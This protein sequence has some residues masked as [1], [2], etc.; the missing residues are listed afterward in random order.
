MSGR[1]SGLPCSAQQCLQQAV[2]HRE[3]FRSLAIAAAGLKARL[4]RPRASTP[5]C[6]LGR[7][8][9]A[10][11][12]IARPG[13]VYGKSRQTWPDTPRPRAGTAESTEDLGDSLRS[14]GSLRPVRPSPPGTM[15]T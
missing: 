7:L 8:A 3:T 5:G 15:S 2:E 10:I 12:M 4:F 11:A 14:E 1:G 9:L 13:R 6:R